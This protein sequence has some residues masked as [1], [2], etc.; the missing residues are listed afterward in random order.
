VSILK[1]KDFQM[2]KLSLIALLLVLMV[3]AL[4]YNMSSEP[5]KV[6]EHETPKEE[7]IVLDEVVQSEPEKP[8]E[9]FKAKSMQK[10]ENIDNN[11]IVS[12]DEKENILEERTMSSG[13]EELDEISQHTKMQK[14]LQEEEIMKNALQHNFK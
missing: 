14:T 12:L 13:L 2:A 11:V 4:Y 5:V 1:I 10:H 3:G 7:K 6:V 8:K 9:L